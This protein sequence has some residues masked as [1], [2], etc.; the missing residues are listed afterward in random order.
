MT[1]SA[2]PTVLATTA[3]HEINFVPQR[4][5]KGHIELKTLVKTKNVKYIFNIQVCKYHIYVYVCIGLPIKG[6]VLITVKYDLD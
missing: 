1:G 6:C 5:I 3:E 2:T 4:I